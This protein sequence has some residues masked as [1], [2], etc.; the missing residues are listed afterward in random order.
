MVD[1]L[2]GQ[3]DVIIAC[4]GWPSC[5]T[6]AASQGEI[7]DKTDMNSR[8]LNPQEGGDEPQETGLGAIPQKLTVAA[9][10]GVLFFS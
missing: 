5:A 1:G 10:L 8:R 9:L 2:D 4:V 3:Q 6:N 7:C